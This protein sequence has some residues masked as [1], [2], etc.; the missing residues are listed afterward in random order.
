MDPR[1][2]GRTPTRNAVAV[3]VVTLLALLIVHPIAAPAEHRSG[4]NPAAV[5]ALL[6]VAPTDP[7]WDNGVARLTFTNPF[8]SFTVSS[9]QDG[10][11][12]A[13]D[14]LNTVAE[15]RPGG[16]V[17]AVGLLQASS[18]VWN[19]T[20]S[21]GT[22]NT[23]VW[24]TG[25]IPVYG[26]NGEW[27]S[28]GGFVENGH[29][30]GSAGVVLAFILNA[31]GTTSPNEARFTVEVTSWPWSNT[32]DE[33]GLEMKDTAATGTMLVA[34]AAP[35][36]MNEV[37]SAT[38]S[39]VASLSWDSE[40]VV[41]YG[42]GTLNASTVGTYRVVALD[43]SNSTIR[44]SFGSVGGG[45]ASLSYDPTVRLNLAA[46]FPAKGLPAWVISQTSFELILVTT[47]VVALLGVA[48]WRRRSTEIPPP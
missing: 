40:A 18:V 8:P 46:E 33:L 30:L 6:R 37:S 2:A 14:S 23:T 34:G 19:F 15:V 16:G 4:G 48:A 44:L 17:S 10:R 21:A 32:G 12:A 20:A 35:T 29:Y 41:R 28:E 22:V 25:V 13:V 26:T 3:L 45:Y 24:L 9:V 42:S 31:S 43:G 1:G 11:I 5:P 47:I 38:Q 7:S 39:L 27:E 36:Q